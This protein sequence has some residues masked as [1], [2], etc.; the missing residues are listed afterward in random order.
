MVFINDPLQPCTS[1]SACGLYNTSHRGFR[2][3]HCTWTKRIRTVDHCCDKIKGPCSCQQVLARDSDHQ[4]LMCV[5]GY[6]SWRA[7]GSHCAWMGD[8]WLVG[9]V[10]ITIK[11]PGICPTTIRW[12]GPC[13][14]EVWWGS[15]GF[16]PREADISLHKETTSLCGRDSKQNEHFLPYKHCSP[17][18]QKQSRNTS[19]TLISQN[20]LRQPPYDS[21][22]ENTSVTP[23]Q[24]KKT[25]LV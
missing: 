7:C 9:E 15:S 25:R 22:A 1:L 14:T 24:M 3:L 2:K 6:C 4:V 5:N 20:I 16:P 23:D 8:L 17:T 12:G 19:I 13:R 21:F 10:K 18:K 11:V